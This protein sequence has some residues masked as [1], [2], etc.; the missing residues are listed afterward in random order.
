MFFRKQKEID[1]L[2][3]RCVDLGQKLRDSKIKNK[4]LKEVRLLDIR[5]NTKIL[6]ENNKKTKLIKRISK[7]INANKY[8][9]EKAVLSKI[10][11]LIS[12]FDSQN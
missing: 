12:D 1:N 2:N 5:N 3:A 8:N 10:K 4:Q 7:L 11:E 6:E 9:N